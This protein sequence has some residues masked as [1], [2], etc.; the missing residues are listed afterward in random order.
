VVTK[1]DRGPKHLAAQQAWLAYL[2][3]RQL[4][5]RLGWAP[6]DPEYGGWGFSLEPP[7]KPSPGQP[8]EFF[9]ESNMAATVFGLA[10]LKSARVPL[11]DPAYAKA[12]RFVERC[13]NF[14]SDPARGDPQFDDGG[15][16]F[17]PN[18]PVQNK[19][20][21]AGTDRFGRRR[22]HSYG[23]MT[24]DGLRALLSC[25]LKVDHARVV[26]A[27]QWL[28]R[29]FTATENPGAFAAD[30]AVLQNATYYYWT[31]SVAHAFLALHQPTIPTPQGEQSWA[32][33]LARTLLE[34]Q[35]PDG[36][37]TS[38]Y[39]DAKEDDPL[40]AT[41]WAAASLAI[42]RAMLTGECRRIGSSRLPQAG[43]QH[44]PQ[45]GLSGEAR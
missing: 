26:A 10:A 22:F 6:E 37:W 28:E 20:G 13:Q 30:R 32:E 21:E 27:R 11:S 36:T 19:P 16:F 24:A 3:E 15:F 2:R 35:R 17:I 31:W 14:A 33:P 9:C 4:D 12:L 41:P 44:G 23:T 25:G 5:E 38:R 7:R 40:V 29:N 42:C 43:L 1:L 39:T 8:R 34:R 18:D 45:T